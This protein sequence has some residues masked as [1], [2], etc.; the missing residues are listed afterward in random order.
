MIINFQKTNK[1]VQNKTFNRNLQ[2][3]SGYHVSTFMLKT[4]MYIANVRDNAN[5]NTILV[6]QN[7]WSYN[8]KLINTQ[9]TSSSIILL[10]SIFPSYKLNPR[11]VSA[12][13]Q[14]LYLRIWHDSLYSPLVLFRLKVDINT[15]CWHLQMI[16]T[17]M[18]VKYVA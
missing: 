7:F 6:A 15:G 9:W 2:N 4:Q 10:I 1:Q 17:F 11:A 14:V 3:L 13:F 5:I 18:I 12:V 8:C 16:L